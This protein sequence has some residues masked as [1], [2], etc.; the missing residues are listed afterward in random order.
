MYRQLDMRISEKEVCDYSTMKYILKSD[1]HE[2][3]LI[4]LLHF[5]EDEFWLCSQIAPLF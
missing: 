4:Q 3:A 2:A 5:S 1:G